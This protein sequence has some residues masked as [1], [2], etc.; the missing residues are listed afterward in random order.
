MSPLEER[1]AEIVR[2]V[3]REELERVRS[4][5][6]LEALLSADQVAGMLGFKDRASVYTLKREGKLKAVELGDRTLRFE[7]QEVRR[8]IRDSRQKTDSSEV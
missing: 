4:G 7:P 6:P 8:F 2:Q 3:V 1:F 5:E